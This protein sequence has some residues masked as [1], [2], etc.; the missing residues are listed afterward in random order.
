[1]LAALPKVDQVLVMGDIVGYGPDPNAVIERLQS[2][3]A[4]AVLGN[5]D[6][7]MLHPALLEEFNPHAAK[8]ARWTRKVLTPTSLRFLASLPTFGRLGKHRLVHGSPRK[9]YIWEYIFEELQ[10]LD[11]LLTLGRRLCFFGHTHLPRVFTAEGEQV[12]DEGDSIDLPEAALVNPGSV[13]QPRD[14]NPKASYA[15]IDLQAKRVQ[16]FRIAYD[17]AATQAKIRAAKLPEVEAVRLA[18]GR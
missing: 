1:M 16:F 15:V 10:A 2:I 11:I 4:R 14:G 8:A 17:V 9:P 5:H 13:G 12:P 7:S 18:L 3:R 6:A